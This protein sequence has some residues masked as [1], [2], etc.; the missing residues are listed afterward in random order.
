MKKK[1]LLLSDDIRLQTGVANISK[2]IVLNS[3]DTYD[4]VQMSMGSLNTNQEIIDVSDSV[5]KITNTSDT[6]VR[7]YETKGYGSRD[8]LLNIIKKEEPSAIMHITD[9]H[10]FSWLYSMSDEVRELMPL[11]YYH[12]WDNDPH[13]KF[14][15]NV[16]NKCDWIGC[17]SK[18]TYDSVKEVTPEHPN[19]E[20][21]PHGVSDKVFFPQDE[22]TRE[23]HRIGLLGKNY[24]FVLL[25][26][27]ANISRKQLLLTIQ[28]FSKFYQK[29][30]EEQKKEVV[31]LLHTDVNHRGGC[32]VNTLLDEIYSD[33]PVLISPSLVSESHLNNIYNLSHC[34]INVAYNEGF[35]LSTLESVFTNTPIILNKTGGLSD[36]INNEWTEVV[37]PTSRMLV[38]TQQVPYLYTDICS[39]D[40]VAVAIDNMYKRHTDIDM[41][42]KFDFILENRFTDKLMVESIVNGVDKTI[43]KFKPVHNIRFTKI[44]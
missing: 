19:Y 41:T 36:Q 9:P 15:R 12:V 4:W 38:G 5:S 44:N 8:S 13:P 7:L 16:Y 32:N 17:I 29:L 25:F 11:M 22:S 2:S 34:T 20:Y 42:D 10:R 37:N 6:Y 1:I 14:L 30:N 31:L 40:D 39:A 28:S 18:L 33:L 21:I 27:N 26:N 35:G 24:K 23:K 3:C 43:K